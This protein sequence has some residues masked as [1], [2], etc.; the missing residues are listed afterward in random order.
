[1][2]SLEEESIEV[3]GVSRVKMEIGRKQSFQGGR[4]G[5][6]SCR[7]RGIYIW[8]IREFSG[9]QEPSQ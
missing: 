8:C 3:E 4:G 2:L 9:G 6:D 7:G 5:D 1:M